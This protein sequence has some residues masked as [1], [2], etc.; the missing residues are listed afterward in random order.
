MARATKSDLFLLVMLQCIWGVGWSAIKYPQ[1]Q[2]G[3]VTLDFW[4][5]GISVVV[6][7]PFV[8]RDL[9]AKPLDHW[10]NSRRLTRGDFIDYIIMGFIGVTGMTLLYNW[11][12]GRSLAANG[13]LISTTVPIL[14][15][16]IAVIILSEKMTLGRVVSLVIALIGVL[17]ISDI[18]WGKLD[19]FG[20]YLFGDLLLLGGALCNSIYVVFS[21]RLLAIASPIVLLFWAQL[22]GFLGTLPFL[23]FEGLDLRAVLDYRWQTWLSLVFLGVVYFALAMIIFYRVLVRLDAGQIMVSNYLM[24]IFGVLT[25]V[26]L[27]NEKVSEN[28]VIGGLL[29]LAGTLAIFQE[30]WRP[31]NGIVA[32]PAA[33]GPST[34][35]RKE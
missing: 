1:S 15:A 5:L 24:P 3:P 27:L 9:S 10:G 32:V 19:F 20:G 18:R 31:K 8:R 34:A 6:L 13:S 16:V 22:L 2:M 17:I 30:P 7:Y 21:K 29:V 14:T 23:P 26:I 12:A 4:I 35:V 28:M 11:G 33:D 25:A